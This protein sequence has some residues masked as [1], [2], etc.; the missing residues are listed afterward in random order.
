MGLLP[1][2]SEKNETERGGRVI[3]PKCGSKNTRYGAMPNQYD[4]CIDCKHLWHRPKIKRNRQMKE[5]TTEI[6]ILKNCPFCG[7]PAEFTSESKEFVRCSKGLQCPTE[8]AVFALK[9]GTADRRKLNSGKY[10]KHYLPFVRLASRVALFPPMQSLS[11]LK[12]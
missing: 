12:K 2:S 10:R 3:C 7:S 4:E 1:F 11:G 8:G 5:I 9:I 6:T